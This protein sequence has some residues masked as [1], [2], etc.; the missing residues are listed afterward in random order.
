M[1][2][3]ELRGFGGAV[4][5]IAAR[6]GLWPVAL[7]QARRMVRRDWW[8]TAPY[9]PVPDRAYLAFR[10]ETQYG[11]VGS[12]RPDDVV[13]YLTWCRDQE[14]LRA[15]G[16]SPRVASFPDGTQDTSVD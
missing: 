16:P 9:L 10:L 12:P 1:T 7:R 2:G 8:R 5:A 4:V 6:P 15:G 3:Q 11:D 14:R 13:T